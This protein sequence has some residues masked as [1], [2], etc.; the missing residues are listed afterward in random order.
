MSPVATENDE[1]RPYFYLTPQQI[2]G[3][4]A[5]HKRKKEQEAKKAL[6]A[7]PRCHGSTFLI[8]TRE[9]LEC[10]QLGGKRFVKIYGTSR[11]CRLKSTPSR[12]PERIQWCNDCPGY[13]YG[14]ETFERPH[15]EDCSLYNE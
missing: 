15:H 14:A 11:S 5:K 3:L 8:K 4:R 12:Y 2:Q 7:R 10:F 1:T 9:C 13:H 6:E